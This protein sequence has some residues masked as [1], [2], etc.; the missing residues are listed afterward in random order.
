MNYMK[1]TSQ[2]FLA[3]MLLSASACHNADDEVFMDPAA[4]ASRVQNITP[5]VKPVPSSPAPIAT[6]SY[7]VRVLGQGGGELCN[8]AVD[9]ELMSDLGF[10]P[11]SGGMVCM[12]KKIDLGRMLQ[13]L[14]GS[15]A[16]DMDVVAD[17]MMI[18]VKNIGGVAFNPPRPLVL[19]PIVQDPT[20]FFGLNQTSQ[21][22]ATWTNPAT[23][24][25]VTSAGT[26]V[27]K[28]IGVNE[29]YNS[30][31]LGKR[32]ERI[33]HWEM[34][35]AGFDGIPK[36]DAL[37]F[38]RIEML[39]NMRPLVIPKIVI[40]G[41]VRSFISDDQPQNLVG[42]GTGSVTGS[43]LGGGQLFGIIAE[44]FVGRVQIE[45]EATRFQGL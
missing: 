45:L 25:V 3:T 31:T 2:L 22:Q 16:P 13:G 12:G 32:F 40:Q 19:G 17:G 33:L 24:Q 30:Q 6:A 20:P 27:V 35:S 9:L 1:V 14:S 39:W 29:A 41:N 5:S 7:R 38:D 4:R 36:S 43:N 28:V 23:G 18:R 26:T 37:I 8:G 34:T 15:T 44:L 11:A 10:G 21:H 42:T